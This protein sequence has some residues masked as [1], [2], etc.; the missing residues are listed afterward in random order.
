MCQ[1]MKS[2][3]QKFEKE[4]DAHKGTISTKVVVQTI[5][6]D[7]C[8]KLQKEELV[9]QLDHQLDEFTTKFNI[10]LK[11]AIVELKGSK[12][13]MDKEKIIYY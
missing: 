2:L 4:V 3:E 11:Q 9:D 13:K 5:A 7:F 6:L 8:G 12:L 1:T 10:D